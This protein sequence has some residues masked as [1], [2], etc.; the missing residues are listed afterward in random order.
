MMKYTKTPTKC[1]VCLRPIEQTSKSV[2]GIGYYVP[3]CRRHRKERD[4]AL[5]GDRI[6]KANEAWGRYNEN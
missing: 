6:A 2:K 1:R 4:K 3:Y 5:F